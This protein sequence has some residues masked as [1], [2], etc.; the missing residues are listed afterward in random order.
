[1]TRSTAFV[2]LAVLL[3]VPLIPVCVVGVVCH[4]IIKGY[5]RLV[6]ILLNPLRNL[7][8]IS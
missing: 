5:A 1:M 2:A 4:A 6:L 3:F 8:D 7:C